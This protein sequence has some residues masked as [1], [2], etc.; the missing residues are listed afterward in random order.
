MIYERNEAQ[1]IFEDDEGIIRYETHDYSQM[2]KL[3]ED[4]EKRPIWIS[5]DGRI[6][7]EAFSPLYKTATDFLI[8]IAEPVSRPT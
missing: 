8:A 6:F 4:H 1:D 5:P 2:I 3:K 7:L